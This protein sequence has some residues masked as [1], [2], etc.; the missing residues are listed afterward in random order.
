MKIF[1]SLFLIAFVQTVACCQ[2]K[3]TFLSK[4]YPRDLTIEN[5]TM[6]K[7]YL[8]FQKQLSATTQ[9]K[10]TTEYFYIK[11]KNYWSASLSEAF[12]GRLTID[13]KKEFA[14]VIYY[15]ARYVAHSI[16]ASAGSQS[17]QWIPSNN[18]KYSL[19]ETIA[20]DVIRSVIGIKPASR[21]N[22]YYTNSGIK[23]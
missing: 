7:P 12:Y 18:S 11:Q 6:L 14:P 10:T 1:I 22:G 21:R 16:P 20:S 3:H 13:R 4:E 23:Y 8:G 2:A 17:Y 5:F 15:D 19:G 9:P